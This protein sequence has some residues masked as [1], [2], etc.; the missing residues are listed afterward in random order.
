M[1]H[2]PLILTIV[3]GLILTVGNIVL[4]KWVANDY[5]TY[6]Y[7]AGL[8]LYFVSM[9]LLA[10]SYKYEDVAVASMIMIIFNIVTLTLIGYFIFHENITIYEFTGLALGITAIL[11][12]EFGKN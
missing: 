8:T 5:R 3:A 9:N 6:Y 7:I 4:K 11:L 10:L 12:L 2:L 1:N